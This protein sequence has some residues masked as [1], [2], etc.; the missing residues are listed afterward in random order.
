MVCTLRCW[1]G[2]KG[3]GSGLH[4]APVFLVH[5]GR[6]GSSA[7]KATLTW[8][9]TL[10]AVNTWDSF[11]DLH[12]LQYAWLVVSLLLCEGNHLSLRRPSPWASPGAGRKWGLKLSSACWRL[13]APFAKPGLLPLSVLRRSQLCLCITVSS[14]PQ[15][16]RL[17]DAVYT[18]FK[19]IFF[20]P[21]QALLSLSPF[22]SSATSFIQ[23]IFFQQR[24]HLLWLLFSLF[25]YRNSDYLL[26]GSSARFSSTAFLPFF[27]P[28][29]DQTNTLS[30]NKASY[31]VF[32]GWKERPCGLW[33]VL[34]AF[35]PCIMNT[36]RRKLSLF[37]LF[38]TVKCIICPVKIMYQLQ[39]FSLQKRKWDKP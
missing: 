36:S 25:C 3:L 21:F 33:S 22:P 27:F 26:E 38:Y 30:E 15:T 17:A 7:L 6:K 29:G 28:Q 37:S 8:Q 32:P 31:S 18:K 24:L 2:G 9:V 1:W 35:M 13:L 19:F 39:C 23:G 5:G 20:K 10:A 4:L 12:V 14:T 11:S 16:A 34:G